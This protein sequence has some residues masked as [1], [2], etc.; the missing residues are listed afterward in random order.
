MVQERRGRTFDPSLADTFVQHARELLSTLPEDS[1]WQ[2]VMDAEPAPQRW[3][4]GAEIEQ[5]CLAIADFVD[6]KSPYTLGHSR[7]VA[8]LAGAA[9]RA[10]GLPEND[11]NDLRLAGLLHDVGR[12]GVSNDVWDKQGPLSEPQ[13]ERMRLHAYYT[14]R[15]LAR[16]HGLVN[17]ASLAG[18]HHERLDGSGYHRGV[19]GRDLPPAARI[20]AAADC[21]DALT[22]QR[23]HRA[24]LDE[25]AAAQ[26][27]EGEAKAERLDPDAVAAVL[28][29]AGVRHGAVRKLV[30]AE[31]TQREIEVLRLIAHG[32]S[33]REVAEQLTLS[34]KT[35]G[36]H[37]EHIYSKIG[38]STRAAATL[39]ALQNGLLE[40]ADLQKMG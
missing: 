3:L 6:I 11:A 1:L 34:P 19:R 28:K 26:T 32:A 7:G 33:N 14:Q 2:D 35:V 10:C 38:V 27:L 12:A 15:I 40:S 4:Q 21:Y 25:K 8:E 30:P 18:A 17:P 9:A 20:L 36:N 5:A 29:A 37:V 24:A 16:L 23:P 31:L 22:H 13:R 39:W